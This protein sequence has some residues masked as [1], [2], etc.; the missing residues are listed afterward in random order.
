MR[1]SSLVEGEILLWVTCGIVKTA[2]SEPNTTF[3]GAIFPYEWNPRCRQRNASHENC[4]WFM[5]SH[6]STLSSKL[7]NLS[8]HIFSDFFFFL[9][10][11]QKKDMEVLRGYL[12]LHQ[13]GDNLTLKWTPNQLINGTLGDCDLEKRWMTRHIHVKKKLAQNAPP[14]QTLFH[15]YLSLIIKSTFAIISASTGT[16]R[17]LCLCA[18]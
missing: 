13:A 17:W 8:F 6:F 4:K 12:S 2:D 1:Y 9:V 11:R 5:R 7:S 14:L 10:P 3:N 16:T 15:N 18:R